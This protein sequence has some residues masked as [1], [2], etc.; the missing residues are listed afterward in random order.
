MS[1]GTPRGAWRVDAREKVTGAA[2]Y[3]ADVSRPG[4]LWAKVLR[5]SLPHARIVAVDTRR[6]RALPGVRAVLAGQDLPDC[7]VGRA[8]RD[9]PVL[10]R[11][12]VRFVGE[13]VVAVAAESAELAEQAVAL[14]DVEYAALPAVFDPLEA[15]R[16]GSPLVH[17]PEE[18]RRRTAPRQIIPDSPN[19]VTF[20]AWGASVEEVEA[21]LARADRVV[22]HVFR[23]PLQHQAYLEPHACTVEVDEAGVVHVWASN[24]APFLLLDYLE[25]GIG[26]TRDRVQIHLLPL[27]GDF[28]GKGSFMDIPL[29][30]YLAQ[31]TG[32]P[33]R[34]QM[35]YAEELM[36][37]NPRHAC[38]LVVRSGL[39]ADGRIV[40]R[41]LRAYFA[42]GAYAAFKPSPDGALP[43]IRRGAFGAYHIPAMRAEAHVV[44]TNTVPSGHM[45]S[46]G[47][48]QTA[49][50][51]ECH[52][53]LLARELGI[54]PVEFRIQ[55]ATAATRRTGQT[56]QG[57]PPRAAEALL[58][59]AA[60]VGWGSPKEPGV[61]RGVA[62]IE[63]TTSPGIY[64]AA[65]VVRRSG[66]VIFR[67]PLVENG[68]GTL[69]VCRQIVA[70]ELGI[71]PNDVAVEQTTAGFEVDRGMGGSRVTRL[72]GKVAME[73]VQRIQARLAALLA[74]ELGMPASEVR[75]APGGF[76]LR[77][78]R[79]V[80]LRQAASLAEDDIVE[81]LAYEA[82]AADGVTVFMAEAA[83]IWVDA[84]TGEIRPLRLASAPE[85]GR[86]IDPLLFQ[87]QVEGGLAQGLGYA[88]MEG[89]NVEEGR[90]TSLNFHEYKIPTI[91]DLPPI[92]SILLP[93]DPSLGITPIG[94]G[95]TA[96][97]APAIANAVVDA[98]GPQPLDIP[99]RP[100]LVR[101]VAQA[102]AQQASTG[103][104]GGR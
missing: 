63:F 23:T 12:K 95:P 96:G 72:E 8:V 13:K 28:G 91:A 21:A 46:P 48:A 1:V 30:Y 20:Q 51:V 19:G 89:L 78:G 43:G 83:E 88:L 50:A 76:G 77:D 11:E 102:W 17:D 67:T 62:L 103:S 16:P 7:R 61:G 22:E 33:V 35:A 32:R 85:V 56:G 80:P 81:R 18:V 4:M 58:A 47:E 100:E 49:Y 90:I 104:R 65:L 42:S 39:A 92:Q 74:D 24:K 5:S 68:A 26:L 87:T 71:P 94:E 10:A 14:I 86:V 82:T 45:R 52:T 97:M 37:G 101:Q 79:Y 69:T 53:E 55:N 54:D 9:M 38:T 98:L 73:L 31:E 41:W 64:S 60:A 27:G 34:L 3:A 40:A 99:L 59:A 66:E 57:A 25:R 84:E 15:M 44:Y 70:D 2:L 75:V 29:A 36:A 93:P 6:A